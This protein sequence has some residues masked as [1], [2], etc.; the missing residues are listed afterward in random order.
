MR[1]IEALLELFY[2][3]IIIGEGRSE[4]SNDLI[5]AR[6]QRSGAQIWGVCHCSIIRMHTMS[7]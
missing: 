2:G 6:S 3:K 5:A 7:E 1:H 4:V